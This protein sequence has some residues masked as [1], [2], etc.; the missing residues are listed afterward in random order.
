MIRI[1]RG[2]EEES[3]PQLAAVRERELERVRAEIAND[4][5]IDNE[6]LGRK[7]KV[8]RYA[9]ARAQYHKCC[10]CEQ[11][12]QSVKWKPV[13]HYRPKSQYWWLTWTWDNLLFACE[14]CN[15]SKLA[16][17]PMEPGSTRLNPNQQPPGAE[18]ALP[19]H[20]AQDDPREHIEFIPTDNKRW[21]PRPRGASARGRATLDVLCWSNTPDDMP[22]PGLLDMW[23]ERAADLEDSIIAI[24]AAI[25]TNNAEHVLRTWTRLTTRYRNARTEFVALSLDIL[26]RH[27]PEHVRRRW[28]LSLD[29]IYDP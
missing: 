28:G 24:V 14:Q 20:P 7:Y 23:K 2:S 8:A 6:V 9:L 10:Y 18:R 4:V 16:Q 17:F 22:K 1:H 3:C 29:V 19:L 27:F 13:E 26:D 15:G 25:E 5:R 12:Q 21:I 11:R